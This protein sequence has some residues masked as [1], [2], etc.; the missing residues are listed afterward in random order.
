M[1]L[2]LLGQ[3]NAETGALGKG[4]APSV[5]ANVP[6]MRAIYRVTLNPGTTD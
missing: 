5:P 2:A 4:L 1:L 3:F 6:G